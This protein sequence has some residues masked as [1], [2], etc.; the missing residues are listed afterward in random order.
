[1]IAIPEICQ[2]IIMSGY[3]KNRTSCFAYSGVNELVYE[4]RGFGIIYGITFYHFSD[5]LSDGSQDNIMSRANHQL[6]LANE[7]NQM[8]FFLAMGDRSGSLQT[9]P[10]TGGESEMFVTGH[11]QWPTFFIFEKV[12]KLRIYTLRPAG[13]LTITFD[14]LDLPDADEPL[15]YAAGDAVRLVDELSSAGNAFLPQYN[16][17]ALSKTV[18]QESAGELV[19]GSD[20]TTQLNPPAQ[21]GTPHDARSYPAFNVHWVAVNHS[22]PNNMKD[23]Y[24]KIR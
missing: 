10:P 13:D 9:S 20:K 8:E 17:T 14:A 3:G 5:Y 23:F 15:G 2:R 7:Q 19:I 4:S 24:D 21:T 22:R 18:N 6:S 12:A 1:M 16:S 11:V